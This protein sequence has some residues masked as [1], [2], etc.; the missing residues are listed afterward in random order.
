MA[1]FTEVSYHIQKSKNFRWLWFQLLNPYSLK[2]RNGYVISYHILLGTC[3]LI[4]PCNYLYMLGLKLIYG[5]R[6]D[7]YSAQPL[8]ENLQRATSIDRYY[9]WDSI[10][11]TEM[12]RVLYIL[13][14]KVW[15]WCSHRCEA[16]EYPS[17][18]AGKYQT[19]WFWHQWPPGGLQGQDTQCRLCSLYGGELYSMSRWVS[20]RKT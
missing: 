15:S 6:R 14:M 10:K 9:Q 17:W 18:W 16:I 3:L 12:M 11:M 2:F 8:S 4:W 1:S 13:C 20:A 5:S 7:P 19:L